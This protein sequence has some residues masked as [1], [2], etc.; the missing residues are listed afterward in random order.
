MMPSGAKKRAGTMPGPQNGGGPGRGAS[1]RPGK[2]GRSAPSWRST[3]VPGRP[4]PAPRV[5][6]CGPCLSPQAGRVARRRRAQDR[7]LRQ[8][9]VRQEPSAMSPAPGGGLCPRNHP[10]GAAPVGRAAPEAPSR[11]DARAP[12]LACRARARRPPC[13]PARPLPRARRK[14]K[15][16]GAERRWK[17]CV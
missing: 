10:A 5:G 1:R 2:R 3:M 8:C 12:T 9:H 17:Q 16:G 15:E 6:R 14:P 13:G 7:A 4:L 11:V